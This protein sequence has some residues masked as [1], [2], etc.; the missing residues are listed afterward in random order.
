[1]QRIV[2]IQDATCNVILEGCPIDDYRLTRTDEPV[3][4]SG[5]YEAAL[6]RIIHLIDA[7]EYQ[8]DPSPT[9]DAVLIA[10]I[11][12]VA[13]SAKREGRDHS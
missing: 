12:S 1:M 7:A 6:D 13:R 3:C 10:E 4:T 8:P 9:I 2:D 11:R 5:N